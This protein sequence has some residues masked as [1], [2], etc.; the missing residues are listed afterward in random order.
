[1][2]ILITETIMVV[3]VVCQIVA[4]TPQITLIVVAVGTLVLIITM[5]TLVTIRL[6]PHHTMDIVTMT[7]L[8]DLLKSTITNI[9]SK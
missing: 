7:M 5:G 9:K 1:M 2:N 8:V 6:H 4:I 3:V